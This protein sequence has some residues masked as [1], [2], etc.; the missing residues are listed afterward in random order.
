M[1]G[2]KAKSL[3]KTAEKVLEIKLRQCKTMPQ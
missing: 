3:L 1:K 2:R